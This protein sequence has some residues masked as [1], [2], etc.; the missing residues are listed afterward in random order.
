M[1]K[2]LAA[3]AT[4]LGIATLAPQEAA[5][6]EIQLTG[7]L[8]GAPSVRK[9]RLYRQGRFEIAPGVAYTLLSEYERTLFVNARLQ[10]N[11]FDWL[12]VGLFGGY[13][14]ASV[15]T[16]LTDQIDA[17]APRNSRTA[18]NVPGGAP[19]R[20]LFNE[21]TGKMT[22]LIN[23]QVTFSPFRG[24]LAIFQKLFVDTDLYFHGG[25]AVV[26]VKE[27]VDCGDTNIPGQPLC[28][29]PASFTQGS[30][31]A[32][33]PSFGLGLTLY[34]SGLVS[35]NLEYRAFPFSWNRGG[36]DSRGGPP[37]ASFPDNKINSED[38]TFK[39]NQMVGLNIGFSL[40]AK[41]TISD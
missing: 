17:N 21:Q 3:A 11:I 1:K 12:G 20:G 5:A 38:R 9:M 18:A 13:G 37:D 33:A 29:A 31:T 4:I 16:D 8:A 23:P 19:G 30:R 25:V 2:L 10:Y 40:P 34:T 32:I 36:F 39:F 27:R 24:K 7:P 14:V 6:Q 28:T 35:V 22:Y 26:G 15:S 41:P